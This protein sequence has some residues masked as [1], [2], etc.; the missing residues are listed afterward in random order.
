[1]SPEMLAEQLA[2]KARG[3]AGPAGQRSRAAQEE[4]YGRAGLAALC[5][6]LKARGVELAPGPEPAGPEEEPPLLDDVQIGNLE[7]ELSPAGGPLG[8]P[9]RGSSD[10]V[11]AVSAL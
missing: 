11:V 6:A 9:G 10:G 7:R 5:D 4:A 2:R 3:R 1:M 8:A